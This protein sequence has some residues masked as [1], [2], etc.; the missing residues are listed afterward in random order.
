MNFICYVAPPFFFFIANN[1]LKTHYIENHFFFGW[2]YREKV[3]P[4]MLQMQHC[5]LKGYF[6]N[7]MNLGG[8]GASLWAVEKLSVMRGIKVFL[9]YAPEG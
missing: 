2:A 9:T 3:C 1:V 4:N 8:G 7:S 5:Y 6:K